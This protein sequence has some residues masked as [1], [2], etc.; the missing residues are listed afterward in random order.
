MAVLV[1]VSGGLP[2]GNGDIYDAA[3]RD[4]EDGVPRPRKKCQQ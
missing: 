3:F 2:A 4:R 1:V